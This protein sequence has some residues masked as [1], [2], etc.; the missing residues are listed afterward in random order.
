MKKFLSLVVVSLLC[1]FALAN[2]CGGKSPLTSAVPCE[3]GNIVW[4]V[5]AS[6]TIQESVDAAKAAGGG[7]VWVQK[8]RYGYDATYDG[9]SDINKVNANLINVEASNIKLYG[10]FNGDE[11]DCKSRP[12]TLSDF[13]ATILV[14]KP[15]SSI[16]RAREYSS[17]TK[18]FVPLNNFVL[19]G[20]NI[21][22]STG[23]DIH[24]G[25]NS[26]LR[27]LTFSSNFQHLKLHESTAQLTG[28]LFENNTAGKFYSPLGPTPGL[29]AGSNLDG[30]TIDIGSTLE[31]QSS[32][33]NRNHIGAGSLI[34]VSQNASLII[35]KSQFANNDSTRPGFL[36]GRLI[37][38]SASTSA[39]T[40]YDSVFKTN[41]SEL[42][43]NSGSTRVSNSVFWKNNAKSYLLSTL[44]PGYLEIDH[45]TFFDNDFKTQFGFNK[46]FKITNSIF[47]NNRNI[48]ERNLVDTNVTY[49]DIQNNTVFPGVGNINVDPMFNNP[50][51]GDFTLK[52]SSPCKGKGKDGTDMGA[53]L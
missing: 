21:Q 46:P 37:D 1:L 31:I 24:F 49:S 35:G 42:I 4:F 39:L 50:A 26:I 18:H 43:S 13:Q 53:K 17:E 38:V 3:A 29:L 19:D 14:G 22:N 52:A 8:G 5:H 12:N 10:G 28:C 41:N 45:S 34:S 30:I 33:F 6:E 40:I 36:D 16:L 9:L 27:N 44:E 20:F 11:T 32:Q 47:W 51:N 48:R 7:E 25:K 15:I 2:S 23:V